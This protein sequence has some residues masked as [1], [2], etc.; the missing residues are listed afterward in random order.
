MG[1]PQETAYLS[2]FVIDRAAI[3]RYA[4]ISRT[5]SGRATAADVLDVLAKMGK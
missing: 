4:L 3:V 1:R 2:T 5:H